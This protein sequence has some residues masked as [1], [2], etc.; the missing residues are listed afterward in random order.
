MQVWLSAQRP[1]GSKRSATDPAGVRS[2][3]GGASVANAARTVFLARPVFRTM[4]L[5][6]ICSDL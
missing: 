1:V 5:M 2:Y 6:L 3:F 4:A